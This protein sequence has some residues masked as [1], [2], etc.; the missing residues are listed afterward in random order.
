MKQ[1]ALHA[2]GLTLFAGTWLAVVAAAAGTV[3]G[4]VA[5]VAA[6]KAPP[7][8]T[9]PRPEAGLVLDIQGIRCLPYPKPDYHVNGTLR[10][11]TLAGE[12]VVQGLR[13]AAD[14]EVYLYASGR[15]EAASPAGDQQFGGLWY[16]GGTEVGLR[17][18]GKVEYGT[19]ARDQTV[20]GIAFKAGQEVT[21]TA[22]GLLS[23]LELAAE[24]VIQGHRCVAGSRVDFHTA[25]GLATAVLAADETLGGVRCQGAKGVA[26]YPDGAL[27]RATCAGR[28]RVDG[29]DLPAGSV[30]ELSPGGM[31]LQVTL[32]ESATVGG[33][34]FPKETGVSLFKGR[35]LRARLPVETVL[36]GKRCTASSDV[37]FYRSGRLR[38]AELAGATAGVSQWLPDGTLV[39]PAAQQLL[40]AAQQALRQR[41]RDEALAKIDA[42]LAQ[43]PKYADARVLKATAL[44]QAGGD[45]KAPL[46]ELAKA[47]AADPEHLRAWS[48]IQMLN[49]Q[50]GQPD[51]AL[52]AAARLF[53]AGPP[54]PEALRWRAEAWRLKRDAPQARADLELA[55]LLSPQDRDVQLSLAWLLATTSDDKCRDPKRA[56]R[57][58]QRAGAEGREP[59]TLDTLAAAYAA[60]GRFQDAAVTQKEA[61][62]AARETKNS[63]RL[64]RAFQPRLA[65]YQAGKPW[66][67]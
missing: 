31:L 33:L 12:Q 11:A 1:H 2:I 55:I 24:T 20:Q 63:E 18:N 46:A 25:G 10:N 62:A 56:L 61:L 38:E 21:F 54:S 45:G 17:E 40:G 30:C 5:D 58:A 59:H 37:H 3:S 28:Q 42:A 27:K 52:A 60:N 7:G 51:A 47:V 36:D 15:L 50:L 65:A 43:V 22:E 67:E 23:G 57:L 39:P 4:N 13:C 44:L 35:P 6:P 8:A 14:S 26:L 29:V 66:R 16:A 32:A 34:P 49:C 41:A 53:E 19:L 48:M 64:L 9:A